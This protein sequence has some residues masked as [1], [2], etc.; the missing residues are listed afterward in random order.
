MGWDLRIGLQDDKVHIANE[1]GQDEGNEDEGRLRG[2]RLVTLAPAVEAEIGEGHQQ[3]HTYLLKL[4]VAVRVDE[5]VL[6]VVQEDEGD[7]GPKDLEVPLELNE[8]LER[9]GRDGGL[10]CYDV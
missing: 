6:L 10:L 7:D 1:A 8:Q 9:H 4:K 2:L 3:D 5:L